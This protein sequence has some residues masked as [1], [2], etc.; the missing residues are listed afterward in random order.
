M[1]QSNKRSLKMGSFY[2]LLT[3]LSLLVIILLNLVMEKLPASWTQQSMTAADILGMEDATKD[4]LAGL[5]DDVTLY[6][7]VRGGQEDTYL[8]RLLA[9]MEEASDRLHVEKTDPVVDPGV[10]TRYTSGSVNQN[11]VVAVCGAK[12]EYVDYTALYLREESD[13]QTAVF[14]AESAICTAIRTVTSETAKKTYLLTGHGEAELS[15]TFRQALEEQGITLTSLSLLA[16]AIPDDCA[17][18]LVTGA[19]TDLTDA[20]AEQLTR[21]LQGGGRLCLFTRYLDAGTPNWN[22]LLAGYGLGAVEGLVVEA[23]SG[24][25]VSE[26]PYYLLPKI[27]STDANEALTQS[28]LRVMFPLTQA[29][30]ISQTLP[31]GVTCQSL[32]TT[33]ANAYSKLAGFAMQTTAREDGDIKGTFCIGASATRTE[34]GGESSMLCWFPTAYAL[35]DTVNTSVSGGNARLLVSSLSWLLDTEGAAVP[36]GKQLGGGT[37]NVN[38]PA[39]DVWSVVVIA[40]VPLAVAL[41]GVVTLRRRK[42]R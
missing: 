3:A 18:I 15:E 27:E 35:N 14:N 25:F 16:S 42:R 28:G 13:S 31:E 6:W 36:S 5:D 19:E 11:S 7:I 29:V 8:E 30:E 40:V 4:F 20:E 21:Y 9:R 2:L 26:Y 24:W 33:S 34:S 38:T 22:A 23:Q 12:S 10:I 32:L 37:L 39:A 1:K 17:C 41:C